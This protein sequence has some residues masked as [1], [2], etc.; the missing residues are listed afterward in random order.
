MPLNPTQAQGGYVVE[1]RPAVPLLRALGMRRRATALVVPFLIGGCA[2][3]ETTRA[4]V[5]DAGLEGV[6]YFL[7]KRLVLFNGTRAPV[8]KEDVEK[9]IAAATKSK[10]EATATK[11]AAE[12]EIKSIDVALGAPGL[13]DERK[14]QLADDK[15][16]A[17]ARKKNADGLIALKTAEINDLNRTLQ[18]IG[19]S[20]CLFSYDIKLEAG[21]VV[22][23]KSARFVAKLKHSP[24]RDDVQTFKVS[25][26]GLLNSADVAAADRSGDILVEAVGAIG[27]FGAAPKSGFVFR[28]GSLSPATQSCET[29]HISFKYLFDPKDVS[30]LNNA[31]MLAGWP[32]GVQVAGIA[33][34]EQ[35]PSAGSTQ[36]SVAGLYY[37]T[38]SPAVLTV[39]QCADGALCD[40]SDPKAAK[41]PIESSIVSLPQYGAISY[42]PMKSSAFVKTTDVVAF[43]NGMLTSWSANRPSGVLEV[44]R[45]PV[46]ALKVL[47]SVPAELIKLRVDYVSQEQSLAGAYAKQ[48]EAAET[49]RKLRECVDAAEAAGADSTTCFSD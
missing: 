49:L 4:T 11:L 13:S 28:G 15:A 39:F 42:I 41:T 30:A 8:R 20:A 31:L 43:E 22:P 46:R 5:A 38:A 6:T 12:A 23:D 7:P 24:L 37:R 27:S 3:V 34:T 21:D 32:F 17:G 35:G 44:V 10:D 18:Q 14:K 29:A 33:R 48:L 25:A 19:A 40:V 1:P 26:N 45:L 36:Q 47:V 16:V 9:K 2:T